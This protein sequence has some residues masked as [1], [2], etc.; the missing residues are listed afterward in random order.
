MKNKF[1]FPRALSIAS[2]LRP[3]S[4]T[5]SFPTSSVS[6]T[7][8]AARSNAMFCS[9]ILT[10]SPD[11]KQF[12]QVYIILVATSHLH[13]ACDVYPRHFS[14]QL[15]WLFLRQTLPN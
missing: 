5:V 7:I 12:Q 6:A 13:Q 9:L 3:S 8:L 15:D 14:P 11:D 2:L 10:V 4:W 1:T